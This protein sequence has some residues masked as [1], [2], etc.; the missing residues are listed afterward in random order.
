MNPDRQF[1]LV[2]RGLFVG[3]ALFALAP[4][5]IAQNRDADLI[6]AIPEPVVEQ[7]SG[8][9][10]KPQ[11]AVQQPA[12]APMATPP[13]ATAN[14]TP[15][16]SD[17]IKKLTGKKLIEAPLANLS[18]ADA[19][20]AEKLRELI[21]LRGDR[22]LNRKDERDAVEIF[23]RD[24]GFKPLWIENGAEAQRTA[25]AIAYLKG[26]D[27]DGMEPSDYPA[28]N[29]KQA[30]ADKL[31][32]QELIYT[33]EILEFVRHASQGR[34]HWSRVTKDV[35]YKHEGLDPADSLNKVANAANLGAA[36]ASFQPPH[37]Q[38]RLLKAQ[39]AEL[40][41][42]N[43][44]Q[45]IRIPNGGVLRFNAKA[46]KHQEDAR[47]PLLRER[48]G[49]PAKDD[50]VYDEDLAQAVA[51][52]QKSKK[53]K[54]DGVL[55]N[56]VVAALNPQI[57][58]KTTDIII[59]NM[60]RWRWVRRDLGKHHVI[61][62]IPGF[63][64]RV[65]EDNKELWETR[66]VVGLPGKETPIIT[67]EM[68]FITVNPTWNVPPSIIA[69][70]Y[71]PALRQDPDAL[72]RIG[73]RVTRRPDGTI[74]VYQPPGDANA[75]GRIRFNFPNKFLVYQHDTPSK[76][77]FAHDERAYSHGCMRVQNPLKYAEVLLNIARPGENWTEDKVKRLYGG[78]EQNLD[79]KV[80]I[81]VHI[82]YNTA[83]VEDG[84]LTIRKDVYKHDAAT[85]RQLKASG[86][87]RKQLEVAIAHRNNSPSRQNLTIDGYDPDR[88][89][90]GFDLFGLFR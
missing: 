9:E 27:A 55:S 85:I 80:L 90:R 21:A 25:A 14:Q 1:G 89:N 8:L 56:D 37:E 36:L 4:G 11:P 54:A 3:A 33:A 69:N 45:P 78:S 66:I 62:S 39:L 81:P 6:K 71:L 48:L 26:V 15:V 31:A 68:K 84:K 46:K 12:A 5:A 30:E 74:H 29:F 24:R 61:V 49:L 79:F 19:A 2:S 53:R 13:A 72:S 43:E 47:V 65:F 18:G 17:E 83:E 10:A 67:Q 51:E 52:F 60:E 63:Y 32:E 58:E 44:V 75:L 35:E 34:V 64:L 57:N 22:F 59:A 88:R 20:I 77:L 41:G 7:P 70:E 86:N 73:L 50:K 76:H 87:E 42:K 16:V 38:Y 23:Y 28:P 40:R 82:V